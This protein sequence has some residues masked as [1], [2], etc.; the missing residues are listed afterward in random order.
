MKLLDMNVQ[1]K[2]LQSLKLIR[3]NTETITRLKKKYP[4]KPKI[5]DMTTGQKAHVLELAACDLHDLENSEKSE[6]SETRKSQCF[7][8]LHCLNS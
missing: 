1:H 6:G 5:T 4:F 3:Q 2:L 8:R 7:K